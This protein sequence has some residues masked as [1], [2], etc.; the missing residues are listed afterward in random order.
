M[1]PGET[2]KRIVI[3]GE[4]A[5]WEMDIEKNNTHPGQIEFGWSRFE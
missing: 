2:S 1:T 5:V 4:W 3:V